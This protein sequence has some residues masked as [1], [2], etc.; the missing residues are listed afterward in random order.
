MVTDEQQLHEHIIEQTIAHIPRGFLYEAMERIR[1]AYDEEYF[2]VQHSKTTLEE[3]R[4]FKLTQSRCFRVDWDFVQAATAHGL[5]ATAKALPQNKWH[6]AYV[7]S[8]V[9]GMTQSY[10]QRIGDL[11]HPARF[12]EA[13]AASARC[14]RLPIDD[15][16]DIYD[17]KK[18][19]ALLA[20]N[21][22][23]RKFRQRDQRL[24]SLMFCVPSYDM[25][26]WAV[27]IS[28][29][30]LLSLYPEEKKVAKPTREPAWKTGTERKAAEE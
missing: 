6:H 17:L 20:H 18:F 4:I 26:A 13:L 9:F 27:S 21:P 8:G 1:R 30:E 7:T 28:V 12:R 5:A 24:G 16:A 19:Y 25:R 11:P 29:P 22:V 14:P 23:G 15:D 3:Q 10:V 2:E